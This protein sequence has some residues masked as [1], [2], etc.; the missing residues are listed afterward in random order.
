MDARLRGEVS[1]GFFGD[2]GRLPS[3]KRTTLLRHNLRN[4]TPA[5]IAEWD[6]FADHYGSCG[7]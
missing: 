5:E 6:V 4:S 3:P 2:S 7:L 1:T